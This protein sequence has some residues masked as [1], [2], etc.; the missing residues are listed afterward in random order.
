MIK[1]VFWRMQMFG[2]IKKLVKNPYSFS[3]ISKGIGVLVGFLFTI[4]QSR[5][6]GAEIKGQVAT[7]NSIVSITSILFGL[8][9][10]HAYPYF[11][12]N[13]KT[14]V[15]PIF[16]KIALLFLG[17]YTSISI[18]AI[19]VFELSAQLIAVFVIT[20][21]LTY[22]AIVSYITLIEVP[23]KRSATDIVV[24]ISELI[25]LIVL[26]IVCPRSFVVG[27][28]VIT[29]KDV[30][31]AILF[32]SWWR[33]RIFVPSE[34]LKIWIP[35]LVKFGFF[36]ML[37]L[38][39]TTLNYRVDIIML[40]GRVP[41]ASI[42]VYSIGILLAERIWLIPDAVKGVMVSNIAKGKDARETAYVIRICNTGCFVIILAIIALGKP[43]ID[44]MF[45]PEFEG[46]YQVTLIV[47]AGVLSMI[48]YK[49]IAAY[50]I[51]L[52]KQVVSFVFL[53]VAVV[54]HII[55][56]LIL[57]PIWGIYGAGISSV[58]SY[59]ICALLFII[60][61]CRTT[62]IPLKDIL[63]IN[64]GDFKKLKAKLR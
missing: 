27:V 44:L 38:L 35:K 8:G 48:Y 47:L 21:L 7:V 25:L 41:D 33:K 39:M 34:S 23:N 62:G 46:A 63:F 55:L 28:A 61:F 36:P 37:S 10:Y 29:V 32:T 43:F 11:K 40:N 52:G 17:I 24:L 18:A 59:A 4:F 16:M 14:D 58:I 20:P 60:Y 22:N 30:I 49:L 1:S 56:N 50:N 51:A 64:K 2:R 57:I 13:S 9:V 19:I 53:S 26:W 54:V 31:K 42:G 3:L 12:R 15:M 6:L 5:Y 45:G